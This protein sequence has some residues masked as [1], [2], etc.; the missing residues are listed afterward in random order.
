MRTF[1]A[2]LAVFAAA[3]MAGNPD[4]QFALD[5][6][7]IMIQKTII[8]Q[9]G[10]VTAEGVLCPNQ[11]P[12]CKVQTAYALG[13]QFFDFTHK[14]SAFLGPDGSGVVT[15]FAN[16]GEY[17][18]DS[19]KTCTSYCP[20]PRGAEMFPLSTNNATDI[21]QTNYLGRMLET[22]Q[23]KQVFPILNITM[24]VDNFYVDLSGAHPVPVADI[25]SLTPFGEAIG[26]NNNTWVNYKAGAQD[27]SHFVVN[28]IAQCPEA[29]GCEQ[30]NNRRMSA[31]HGVAL[32]SLYRKMFLPQLH[33]AWEASR[34]RMANQEE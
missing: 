1:S 21:G 6:S 8:N 20:L 13:Q 5:W 2:L 32:N 22:Y 3:A 17:A 26:G 24:E 25:D 10:I 19:N 31:I 14:R 11:A 18:V 9:G 23:D 12:Q 4:P 27:A 34:A 7:S 15:L 29:Q 33:G 30:S 28:G 16:G